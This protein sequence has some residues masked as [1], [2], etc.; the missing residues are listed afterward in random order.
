MN[1]GFDPMIIAPSLFKRQTASQQA[2]F[3]FGGSQVPLHLGIKGGGMSS[4]K[5]SMEVSL[6]KPKVEVSA[7]TKQLR[8]FIKMNNR[9]KK[10]FM[11]EM[12]AIKEKKIKNKD[13]SE[14]GM[15]VEYT[16]D[17]MDI[18]P[19]TRRQIKAMLD[20]TLELLDEEE[21]DEIRPTGNIELK[22]NMFEALDNKIRRILRGKP[23]EGLG[24]RIV[25][26]LQDY[27][28]SPI[29]PYEEPNF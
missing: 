25:D 23:S 13:Y 10:A 11:K 16:Y 5:I 1:S 2:P 28:Q 18:T 22:V 3:F 20:E 15:L 8:D 6:P 21:Q 29:Q 27:I 26:Y 9:K 12:I 7:E 17:E 24:R 19:S 4:S 14:G